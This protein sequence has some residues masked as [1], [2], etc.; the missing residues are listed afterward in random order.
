MTERFEG[1]IED[2]FGDGG[3]RVQVG[4]GDPDGDFESGAVTV[5]AEP[6]RPEDHVVYLTLTPWNAH[7]ASVIGSVM[8][9]PIAA[10]KLVAVLEQAL[11]FVALTDIEDAVG[12]RSETVVR[13]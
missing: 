10:R 9:S 6:D 5:T 12:R 2:G 4:R 1:A 13:H 11:A 3:G 7:D 8:L